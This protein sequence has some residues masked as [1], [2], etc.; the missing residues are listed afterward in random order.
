[1]PS[2]HVLEFIRHQ[3]SV[4]TLPPRFV[5]ALRHDFPSVR[6]SVPRDQE[7]ADGL[8]PEA[9]VVLGWAVNRSN[10]ARATRLRW[11]QVTAAGVGPLLFPELVESP[12]VLTNG[13]TLHADAMAEHTLGVMLAFVRKL[14]LARD[15]QREGRWIQDELWSGIESFGQ[16]AGTTLGLVGLGSVGRAI[17]VRARSLGLRVL[18]V[19]KHPADD[20]AVADVQWGLDALPRLIEE[21]DWL[22]LAA[23]LTT[24]TRGLIGASELE[25]MRPSAVLI[26]LGRGSLVD[27]S[28]LIQALSAGKIAGAAL[29]V[30]EREPLPAQSRLWMMPQ[31]IITPHISGTGPRYW[32][33]ALDLFRRNLDR[34]VKGE[35]L[36]NV[37][38]K[39]AGY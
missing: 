23:P 39:R 16:L 8:L 5:D 27:E 12:V 6:F 21:S 22:V 2:F 29:D 30:F 15:A 3:Q 28:A 37:V 10:F 7:E 31:V 11:I 35:P 4:W 25:H 20:P 13:R 18:A 33:R 36:L 19:R 17:A 1:M 34:F 26:N 9:D 14:H 38:D 32:E 24:E